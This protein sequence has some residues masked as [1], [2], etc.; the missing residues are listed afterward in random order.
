MINAPVTRTNS[1]LLFQGVGLQ[2]L[3]KPS[4]KEVD[5]AEKLLVLWFTAWRMRDVAESPWLIFAK[6][7]FKAKALA[8]CT[9]TRTVSF[10]L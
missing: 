10:V 3:E 5:Y 8:G 7:R 1:I 2:T 9:C 6:R 4:R